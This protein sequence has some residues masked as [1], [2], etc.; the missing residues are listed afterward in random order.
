MGARKFSNLLTRR[1]IGYKSFM[2]RSGVTTLVIY[3]GAQPCHV[4]R[5]RIL[6]H[7]PQCGPPSSVHSTAIVVDCSIVDGATHSHCQVCSNSYI[8]CDH[9][10]QLWW[11]SVLFQKFEQTSLTDKVEGLDQIDEGSVEG[12]LLFAVFLLQLAQ[13]DKHVGGAPGSAEATLSIGV[14]KL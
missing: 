2:S 5:S 14:H 10:Q 3:F 8:G 6:W 7:H 9:A 12:H 11:T 4:S 1:A 13:G